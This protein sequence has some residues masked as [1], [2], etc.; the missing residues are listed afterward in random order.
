MFYPANPRRTLGL[1]AALVLALA[2]TG[3]AVAAPDHGGA[4]RSSQL[5][6]A[7]KS[8]P[9]LARHRR[10][11]RRWWGNGR[12][13]RAPSGADSAARGQVAGIQAPPAPVPATTPAGAGAAPVKRGASPSPPIAGPEPTPAPEPAPTPEPTPEP[14]PT[15]APE[16]E[17]APEP[18]P[19]PEP[20][21]SSGSL[22][23]GVDGGHSGWGSGEIAERAQLG[24]AVTRHEWDPTEPVSAEEAVVLAAA[25]EIHTRIHA[26]LGGN[27]LGDP[28]HYGEWVV[29]FVRHYGSGGTFWADHPQL[30]ASRYAIRTIELGNEPYFGAMSATEYADAVLPALERIRDLQ[31]PVRVLLAG[32]VYGEDSSWV[33]GL[34]DRIPDLNSLFNGFAFH[35]YW[36]AHD[37]AADSPAGP[38]QRIE[39]LRERMDALGAG[40]KPIYLTEY[41][42][43]TASC[44][45]ECV[46]EAVQAEHLGAMIDAVVA[47]D[48]WDVAMLSIF[49]L[50]DRGAGSSDR[51]LQFGLLRQDGTAKPAYAIV[52]AA[53][54]EFHE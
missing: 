49:Q 25:S 35:P 37:P 3:L 2:T 10:A 26:L 21:P 1:L 27:D 31:L 53:M 47:R 52:R 15:P 30:D 7:G 22:L 42:E 54:A 13:V 51:E 48:A 11:A 32:Y 16:P 4:G 40:A 41:G 24:A 12:P 17:P 20:L 44:G 36:Y 34:Y 8:T 33:D 39:T 46:S 6:H 28:T 29:A 14:E 19:G 9:H 23:I 18:A 38:F 43:S 5:R 50:R 45:G